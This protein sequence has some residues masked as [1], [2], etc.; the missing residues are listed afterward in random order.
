MQYEGALSQKS[1]LI[2]QIYNTCKLINTQINI[3]DSM[4]DKD[5]YKDPPPP[6]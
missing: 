2:T 4:H 3:K 5:A 6:H 1:L